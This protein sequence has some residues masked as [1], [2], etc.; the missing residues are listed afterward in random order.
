MYDKK[1]QAK[2]NELEK[3]VIALDGALEAKLYGLV[4]N[5]QSIIEDFNWLLSTVKKLKE[6]NE[7]LVDYKKAFEA[8][9]KAGVDLPYVKERV[10]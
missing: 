4:I 7:N 1:F 2:I 10:L 3:E 5:G 9:K 8:S 6:E